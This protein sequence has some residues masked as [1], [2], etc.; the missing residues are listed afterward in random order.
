MSATKKYAWT[1]YAPELEVG[2]RLICIDDDSVD[3]DL[4]FSGIVL[5]GR[6]DLEIG[7][8]YIVL[9]IDATDVPK[10]AHKKSVWADDSVEEFHTVKRHWLRVNVRHATNNTKYAFRC[11]YSL[12]THNPN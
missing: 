8:E 1:E 5:K 10:E 7:Q 4:G 9:S 12:F 6:R 2:S 11:N 3:E